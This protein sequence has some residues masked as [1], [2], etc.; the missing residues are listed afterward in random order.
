MIE[1]KAGKPA[2]S[3]DGVAL[4]NCSCWFSL[5]MDADFYGWWYNGCGCACPPGISAGDSQ[6]TYFVAT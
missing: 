2:L 4:C 3:D 6:G 1:V 5:S